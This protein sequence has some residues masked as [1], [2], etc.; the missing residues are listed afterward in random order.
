MIIVKLAEITEPIKLQ[1]KKSDEIYQDS[2]QANY[3]NEQ[4]TPLNI[5]LGMS[6]QLSQYFKSQ[7]QVY[8]NE[9]Q[10]FFVRAI[11]ASAKSL[12]LHNLN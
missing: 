7:P 2:I 1:Q 5:I 4:M 12:L 3:S 10:L 11:F 8:E 6:D 9:Q